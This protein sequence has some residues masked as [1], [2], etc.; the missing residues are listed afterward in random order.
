MMKNED[1]IGM[2]YLLTTLVFVLQHIYGG[3]ELIGML[4]H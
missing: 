2:L 3:T 1:L 4:Y